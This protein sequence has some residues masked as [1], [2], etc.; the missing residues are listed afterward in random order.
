MQAG[1]GGGAP[2]PSGLRGD[3][4]VSLRSRPVLTKVNNL[5][6]NRGCCALPSRNDLSFSL[7]NAVGGKGGSTVFLITS[8]D[9]PPYRIDD[10]A[11]STPSPSLASRQATHLLLLWGDGVVPRLTR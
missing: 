4:V 2:V 10:R 3:G 7:R 9:Y 1:G 6:F 8:V 5:M 11:W